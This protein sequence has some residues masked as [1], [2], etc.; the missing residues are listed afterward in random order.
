MAISFLS[1]N[2]R[3]NSFYLSFNP[4]AHEFFL[5][6]FDRTGLDWPAP[7]NRARLVF[8][9][10]IY[11][12][13]IILSELCLDRFITNTV[14]SLSLAAKLHTIA[15]RM[16]SYIY[17]YVFTQVKELSTCRPSISISNI[18]RFNVP[19]LDDNCKRN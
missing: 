11:S 8:E 3:N 13:L 7:M 5:W 12:V 17:A 14:T 10:R 2:K 4:F 15:K 18:D 6:C 19:T 9:A 1:N 16:V